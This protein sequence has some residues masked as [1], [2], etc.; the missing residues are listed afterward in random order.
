MTITY[1]F[2]EGAKLYSR[3]GGHIGQIQDGH[4]PE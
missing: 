3:C 4:L 1:Q 2:I